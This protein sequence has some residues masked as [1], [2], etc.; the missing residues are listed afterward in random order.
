MHASECAAKQ[1]L[2]IYPDAG[3]ANRLRSLVSFDELLQR[4]KLY[5]D[6]KIIWDVSYNIGNAYWDELFSSYSDHLI[7]HS[8][9]VN[10]NSY[11]IYTKHPKEKPKA[12]FYWEHLRNQ[13]FDIDSDDKIFGGEF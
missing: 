12:A 2:V 13:G 1:Q 10:S 9:I 8:T 5:K 6:W 4:Y 11:A 7:D 3:L